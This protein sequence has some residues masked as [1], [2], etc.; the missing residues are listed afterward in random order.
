MKIF[1]AKRL[2]KDVITPDMLLRAKARDPGKAFNSKSFMDGKG[3]LVGNL[4]DEIIAS[5]RS[6]FTRQSTFDY[7]FI[8]LNKGKI[9]TIDNK[10]KYQSS[11][12]IPHNI[13]EWMASVCVDSV[14]QVTDYYTFCRVCKIQRGDD[15]IY[16]FGYVLG[17]ISKQEF[18]KKATFYKKGDKEGYN[19]YVVKQ[20]CYSLPYSMLYHIPRKTLPIA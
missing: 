1:D 14:H 11:Q 5:Y 10:T 8:Y 20:A 16:P 18:F 4:G 13:G 6:D 9:V 2:E 3:T 19:N 7:D 17:I 15:Y 12:N